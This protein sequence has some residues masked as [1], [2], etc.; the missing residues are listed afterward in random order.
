[1]SRYALTLCRGCGRSDQHFADAVTAYKDKGCPDC[2]GHR[3]DVVPHEDA[4]RRYNRS[5]RRDG[6]DR[7]ATPSGP[8][9]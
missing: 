4:E 7:R 5:R 1:M 3:F 9:P 2:S 8:L 6:S